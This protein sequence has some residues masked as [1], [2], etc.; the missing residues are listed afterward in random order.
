[1]SIVSNTVAITADIIRHPL[2]YGRLFKESSVV[3]HDSAINVDVKSEVGVDTR[4]NIKE[5]EI[6][7]KQLENQGIMKDGDFTIKIDKDGNYTIK[8][9]TDDVN[10][11]V[12]L[13]SSKNSKSRDDSVPINPHFRLIF[14][15][16]VAL[17]VLC[18]IGDILVAW[19][20]TSPNGNQQSVFETLG[21]VWKAGVGAI[22]GLLGGKVVE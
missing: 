5:A 17:T 21:F 1:M 19:D 7:K 2:V 15:T 9:Q 14:I 20:W 22:F 4:S 3:V 18:G 11:Y 8:N 6:V 16:V 10:Q 12:R 13:R